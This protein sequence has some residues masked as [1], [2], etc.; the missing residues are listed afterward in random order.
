MPVRVTFLSEVLAPPA[1][2]PGRVSDGRGEST[3]WMGSAL[4]TLWLTAAIGLALGAAGCGGGGG[5]K[6]PAE[7][8][9]IVT[10]VSK[11]IEEAATREANSVKDRNL[12]GPKQVKTV[13]L[14]PDQA[15]KSGTPRDAVQC[16]VEAFTTPT[17]KLPKV[18]YVW[19]EDWRVP[20]QDGTL[21]EPEIVGA[22]RIKNFLRKDD[23][24]NCS[25]GKT[26][27]ERCTGVFTP[28]PDQSGIQ[29]GGQPPPTGGQ[30]EVPVNP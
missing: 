21:G 11:K 19:S 13:C 14:P 25:G 6:A 8:P 10:A 15:A 23:R 4:R 26:S 5:D 18:A 29:G 30:Q 1:P 17:K 3:N 28:P 16:H 24:L 12:P 2:G 20:V 27:Q 22:Y 9:E 7:D